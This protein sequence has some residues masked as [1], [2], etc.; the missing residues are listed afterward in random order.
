M[1]FYALRTKLIPLLIGKN[2]IAMLFRSSIK[3]EAKNGLNYSHFEEMLFK[4][5]VK[6]KNI[7]NAPN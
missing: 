3:N 2:A 4:I 6:G 1:N 5:A 7:L